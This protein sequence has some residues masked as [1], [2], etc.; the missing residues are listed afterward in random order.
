M[1]AQRQAGEVRE[2]YLEQVTHKVNLKVWPSTA[3]LHLSNLQ[4]C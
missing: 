1:G 4:M 2:C 3:A